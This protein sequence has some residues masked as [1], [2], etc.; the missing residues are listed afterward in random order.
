M[1]FSKFTKCLIW[2]LLFVIVLIVYIL[3]HTEPDAELYYFFV[4]VYWKR[5]EKEIR[6]TAETQINQGA[7]LTGLQIR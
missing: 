1:K 2:L 3:A 4:A 7:V 5:K 6:G